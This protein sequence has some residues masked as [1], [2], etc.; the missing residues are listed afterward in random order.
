MR[1]SALQVLDQIGEVGGL[2]T[3]YEGAYTG[4]IGGGK[5]LRHRPHQIGRRLRSTPRARVVDGFVLHDSGSLAERFIPR[6]LN[7]REPHST[8]RGR[9]P[10]PWLARLKDA[11]GDTRRP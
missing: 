4:K 11:G 9:R 2:E 6:P 3:L 5:R 10:S 1:C 7:A 8:D